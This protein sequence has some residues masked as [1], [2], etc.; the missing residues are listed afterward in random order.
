MYTSTAAVTQ[1]VV[2][3]PIN[4]F[5]APYT[6][7][8][9]FQQPLNKGKTSVDTGGY[10]P[11]KHRINP[12][13]VHE[14]HIT[15]DP[16]I[17]GHGVVE[18]TWNRYIIST[19]G[20]PLTELIWKYSYDVPS[21]TPYEK[22][23]NLAI[24]AAYAKLG[25]SELQL[26]QELGEFRE[27]LAMLK[28][29]LG[30]LHS[31]LDNDSGIND[32]LMRE[33]LNY[34]RSGVW[35]GHSGKRALKDATAIWMEIR[36]G[37]R[38]LFYSIGEVVDFLRAGPVTQHDP[39]LIRSR[40]RFLKDVHEE[41]KVYKDLH[42]IGNGPVRFEVTSSV[43]DTVTSVA[44]VQFHQSGPLGKLQRLG[45]SPRYWPESAW[46]LGRLTFVWDWFFS[47]GPAIQAFRVNPEI[48]VLGCI[49]GLKVA[50]EVT[51]TITH[52]YTTSAIGPFNMKGQGK[53]VHNV[54]DRRIVQEPHYTPIWVGPTSLDI[55]K[56]I[57]LLA[58]TIQRTLRR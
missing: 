50:R 37:L 48:K 42:S 40:K 44:A 56:L 36:Y 6:W 54:Y 8:V 27:T 1:Q 19:T 20:K 49:G 45:L 5:Y 52:A 26:V 12:Y 28:D 13:L 4:H 18:D 2:Y 46:E 3:K 11:G 32:R 17:Q 25:K 15:N 58:L 14:Q 51:C 35:R 21:F 34:L 57:D 16:D 43:K 55:L 53:G 22:W 30:K 47:I 10:T 38:P 9:A 33:L 23:R 24:Q 29:P 39:L 31:W 41:V 7:S